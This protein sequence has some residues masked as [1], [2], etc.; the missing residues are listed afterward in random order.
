MDLPIPTATGRDLLVRVKAV[1][2]NPVRINLHLL[3]RMKRYIIINKMN[4][5]CFFFLLKVDAK[6]RTRAANGE[7]KILGWDAS[8]VVEG[9]FARTYA[10]HPFI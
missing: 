5:I 4:S 7:T 10:I 3:R 9:N 2:T 1:A 8:G 6:V